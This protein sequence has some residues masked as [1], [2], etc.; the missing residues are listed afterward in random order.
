MRQALTVAIFILSFLLFG[1]VGYDYMQSG[2]ELVRVDLQG[3]VGQTGPIEL[4]PDMNP[5]RL[6]LKMSYEIEI[7]E[8]DEPA[9]DYEIVLADVKGVRLFREVG[10]QREKRD[11][12][13]PVFA[14]KSMAHVVQTFSVEEAGQYV[15]DWNITAD[16]AKIVQQSVLFRRNVR[17]F[18]IG[19]L[20]AGVICFGLGFLLLIR[21]RPRAR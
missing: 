9:Y 14:A 13:T 11:D 16:K 21:R 2:D 19:Y 8:I 17:P 3:P 5:I 6:I 1:W 15:V 10:G 4:D 20:I 12:N 18:Q 7:A